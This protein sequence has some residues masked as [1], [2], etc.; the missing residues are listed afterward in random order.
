MIY[1]FVPVCAVPLGA[2]PG[3]SS[4]GP[5]SIITSLV[6]RTRSMI[7][8][9]EGA[10]SVLTPH[11]GHAATLS[12]TEGLLYGAVGGWHCHTFRVKLRLGGCEQRQADCGDG[13]SHVTFVTNTAPRAVRDIHTQA[14]GDIMQATDGYRHDVA[15][16]PVPA[17]LPVCMP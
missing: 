14:C 9:G 4:D 13:A 1:L 17:L 3:P 10:T 7:I 15:C 16:L 2:P 11:T 12:R 6:T 5:R 8:I